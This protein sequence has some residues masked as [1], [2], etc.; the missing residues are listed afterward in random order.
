MKQELPTVIFSLTKDE[1][2]SWKD[3][4]HIDF[5]DKDKLIIQYVEPFY[6]ENESYDGYYMAEV[7]RDITETDEQYEKRLKQEEEQ[8]KLLRERRYESYLR[9]KKEFEENGK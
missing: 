4:K 9:L 6:S 8:N 5:Q 1:P 7:I 2:I 3:V